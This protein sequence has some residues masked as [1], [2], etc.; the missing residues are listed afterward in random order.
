MESLRLGTSGDP[1]GDA[2]EG[3][4]NRITPEKSLVISRGAAGE[5]GIAARVVFTPDRVEDLGIIG[6]LDV[7]HASPIAINVGRKHYVICATGWQPA[8]NIASPSQAPAT[9]RG[10]VAMST[11]TGREHAYQ[12]H[13]TI[14][15]MKFR[16]HGHWQAYQAIV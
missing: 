3:R 6:R 16:N 7:L 13:Q 5:C 9:F 8:P 2:P 4:T 14:G 12:E 1:V 15:M 10:R 11:C